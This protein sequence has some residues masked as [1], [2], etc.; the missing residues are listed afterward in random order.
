[1]SLKAF[2]AVGCRDFGRV[3]WMVDNKLQNSTNTPK[4]FAIE[5]N[6][7]PGMT[8]HSLLPKA[9]ARCDITF[10]QLCQSVIEMAIS[11]MSI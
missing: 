9:A 8:S 3:D 11:R 7:I 5:I 1:M 6:T 10:D 2:K 4:P